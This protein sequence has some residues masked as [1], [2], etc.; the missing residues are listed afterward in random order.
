MPKKIAMAMSGGVDSSAA[1][2]LL[3]K[4]GY[5]VTG[6][7]MR[8]WSDATCPSRRENSCCDAE[9]IK[10]ARRVTLKLGIPLKIV[11]AKDIFKKRVVDDFLTEFKGLKTPN[12][13]VK[14]NQFVKFG[15]FLRLAQTLGFDKIATGHYCRL[16]KD[17]NGVYHL[18]EGADKTKDQSYF[19]YRLNQKQLAKTLFPVGDYAKSEIWKIAEKNNLGRRDRRE[20]QEICFVQDDDYRNFLK[21][22]VPAKYFQP[23]NITDSRGKTV[24]Q[25]Q[26]L[27]NYTIGQRKGIEQIVPS[28]EIKLPFYV[29]G[30]DKKRNQLIVGRDREIFA[31]EMA[32]EKIS[33]VYPEASKIALK[34]SGLT[35]KIR[36]GHPPIPCKL[37][38]GE[39]TQKIRVVFPKPVRAITP[40]QSAVFYRGDEVL[41]G[42][43]I[44]PAKSV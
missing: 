25:H 19:L 3:K 30:F 14:C 21:R 24:G 16:K 11:N 10:S 26:G 13:C 18:I 37:K 1:A 29:V 35:V 36:Y 17:Q 7:F 40:G 20:S 23:G 27:I 34:F 6:F 32:L 2:H 5:A 9:S 44:L 38:T 39:K 42:G 28:G 8:F 12:P 31:K 41:G 4:Q 43:L 22:H 15:W 33:W